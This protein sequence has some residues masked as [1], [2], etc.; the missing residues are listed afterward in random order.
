MIFKKYKYHYLSPPS[1]YKP[2]ST[3]KR[4]PLFEPP[5]T[6]LS[7]PM[8]TPAMS[9]KSKKY[10]PPDTPLSMPETNY[11]RKPL[12]PPKLEPIKASSSSDSSSSSD[13][14]S[15]SDSSSESEST[16]IDTTEI[17]R[18]YPLRKWTPRILDTR[19]STYPPETPPSQRVFTPD[20]S[21]RE[22]TTTLSLYS[23]LIQEET[24]TLERLRQEK[25]QE[26]LGK[27]VLLYL[28]QTIF[29]PC[30]HLEFSRKNHRRWN[31]KVAQKC[32]D[33]KTLEVQSPFYRSASFTTVHFDSL[34][35]N[36]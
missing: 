12:K 34:W 7:W 22:V 28:P 35:P 18:Q 26:E 31:W 20:K 3:F 15:S 21:D 8:T 25:K 32:R 19:S 11:M 13:E 29:D 23:D 2:P 33:L 4:A 27:L 16:E 10:L 14:S 17:N 9:Q 1:S 30:S 6:P 5:D 36:H 24:R